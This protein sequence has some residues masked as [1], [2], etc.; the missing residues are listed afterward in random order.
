VTRTDVS[1]HFLDGDKG[2][3]FV[4]RRGPSNP[5]GCV[6]VVPPF[7]EEMNKCRRM[8]TRVTEGVA[9]RG[10]ATVLPDLYGTGDS[11]GDFAD[12]DWDT[13]CNDLVRTVRW[14]ERHAGPV[15][16][17]LAIRLGCALACD[18]R[19]RAA[20]PALRRVV[21]W[22]PVLDGRRFLNQFLR[23]RV[24]A[25]MAAGVQESASDLRRRLREGAVLEISGYELSPQLSDDLERV[26]PPTGL[27][28]PP[29]ETLWTEVVSGEG[30]ALAAPSLAL[31]E[32]LRVAGA[33]LQAAVVPGE[34]FWSTTE[35]VVN[36]ALVALT[37]HFHSDTSASASGLP[38]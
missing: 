15:T 10:I 35:I 12:A 30:A 33:Q 3:I 20:L 9:A 4:L 31:I 7:A 11:G 24:A 26:V 16:D 2:P 19:V 8:I 22:Q 5:R 18:D 23:L 38:T 21:F 6:L 1:G 36:E 27:S 29:A 13:W 37:V 14:C 25:A 32:R 17:L 34:P 28:A